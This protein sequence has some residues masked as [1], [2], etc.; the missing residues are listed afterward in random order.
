MVWP[1]INK[2]CVQ[3]IYYYRM[4]SSKYGNEGDNKNLNCFV[5][6]FFDP[7]ATT[8]KT[9]KQKRSR[10]KTTLTAVQTDVQK[11]SDIL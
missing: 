8:V 10:K 5:R 3:N 6:P 4:T 2:K 7:C 11:N 9:E 1:I